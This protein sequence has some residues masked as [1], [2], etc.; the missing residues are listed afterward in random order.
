[1]KNNKL[2]FYS[3]IGLVAATALVSATALSFA[4]GRGEEHVA[5]CPRGGDGAHCH[6]R[7][8]VDG[9]GAP[10]TTSPPS[11]YGPL[12]FRGAYG[13]SG[14]TNLNQT[15]AIVDAYNDPNVLTDLNTYSAKY[16]I[17]TM[18]GCPVSGGTASAPCFQKVDQRGGTAYPPTN[19]GWV[20]EISLD[21][22]VA[23]A[24]CQNC[25]ILLVEADSNSFTNLLAAEDRAGIMGANAISNSW[26]GN[27]FSGET[28][29]T[30][31]GHFNKPGVVITVSSGDSGYGTEYPAAS[32]YVTAVGGTSLS[33][34]GNTRVN[35]TAWSGAGSGCSSFETKPTWQT[36]SLCANRTV[37]DVSADADPSTGAA[38][39]DSVRYQGR[40]GWFKVGG[41]SLSSPL[42]AGVYAL[43]HDTN[44]SS[45]ANSLPYLGSSNLHDVT[46]GSNGSCGGTYLCTAVSGYDGPTGLGTPNSAA[47]F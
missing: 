35:E 22:E 26:G 30:Y 13:V 38:V 27:E 47:A 20:L 17:P 33:M 44:A 25:N 41:T 8:I 37:A 45:S 23:H 6:A 16:Y 46:A 9:Q 2:V 31:D 39:Y 29:S 10:R 12:Q 24:M 4:Q 32:Q 19:S 7:V 36:D 14:V 21:V 5:V 11:G 34:S 15:I 28:S 1:M 18:T 3:S 40:L 43:A 42:I